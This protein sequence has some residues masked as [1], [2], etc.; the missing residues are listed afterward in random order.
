LLRASQAQ[1]ASRTEEAS[2]DIEAARQRYEA[3]AAVAEQFYA[4]ASTPEFAR[5]EAAYTVATAWRGA[6]QWRDLDE[7]RFGPHADRMTASIREVHARDPSD[8][9]QLDQLSDG[10]R[11]RSGADADLEDQRQDDGV[12]READAGVAADMEYDSG[13][14]RHARE[15]Q[16][17]QSDFHRL[18]TIEGVGRVGASIAG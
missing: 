10:V 4:R 6:Q 17:N 3:Q 12:D 14:S 15:E 2:V 11:V 8:P 9:A 16:I 18:F 13:P 7:A 1:K 5:D